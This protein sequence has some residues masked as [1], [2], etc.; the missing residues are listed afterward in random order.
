[1]PTVPMVFSSEP[2]LQSERATR[3]ML[4]EYLAELVASR[5]DAS[6]SRDELLKTTPD[7]DGS[8]V[9]KY[10][11]RYKTLKVSEIGIVG[12]CTAFEMRAT[13][14]ANFQYDV[15]KALEVEQP[16]M[17]W[18]LVAGR[19]SRINLRAVTYT[20]QPRKGS[21]WQQQQAVDGQI[22]LGVI[23]QREGNL[24][25]PVR[26]HEQIPEYKAVLE[27]AFAGTGGTLIDGW[28]MRT[29]Q[30]ESPMQAYLKSG[31]VLRHLP[32]SLRKQRKQAVEV[33]EAYYAA[34]QEAVD[35]AVEPD[36]KLTQEQVEL[37]YTMR[38]SGKGWSEIA[39]IFGTTHQV[40][41]GAVEKK[42]RQEGA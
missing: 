34:N 29:G 39:K 17:Q 7:G 9:P 6:L 28:A 40:V 11:L 18:V 32:M 23:A 37:A 1:M 22:G 20:E 21:F 5:V 24:V 42:L 30:L 27:L 36:R 14:D 13:I 15:L 16:D 3:P 25:P 8:E 19:I 35:E 12:K 4:Y 38:Q 10:E 41:R 2:E 31:R 26:R 33:I